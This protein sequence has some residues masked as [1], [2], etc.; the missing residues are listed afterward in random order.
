MANADSGKSPAWKRFAKR[1]TT[2]RMRDAVKKL[3]FQ[4][5]GTLHPRGKR[6]NLSDMEYGINLIGHIRGD[7]GLGESCRLVASALK[8]SEIPFL[9]HNLPLNGPA[10][11][12]DTTWLEA[13]RDELVYGVNLIHLNP[14]EIAN[15]VWRLDRRALHD[16]YNIAYWLWELPEFPPEWGY[17]FSLFDE[18]W[19]P[20]EF[21]SDAIRRRTKKPILTVPYALS[22]PQTEKEYSR[23][24]FGLPEDMFLFML[25][26][27]GNSV[28]ERKN[29]M[30]SVRAYCK[31]F[32][33]DECSV[34]LVIKATH[35]R[36]NDLAEL[37]RMLNG[38]P[39]IFVLTE[40][41]S[42]VEFNS[43][44]QA[45]DVYVSLHRAEGFGLV[46][47]EAMLL[48]TAVVAT[49][50]SANTEFMDASA[51]CMVR[52]DVVA[53]PQD[54]P[55][56]HKGDHWAEPDEAEA[57]VYMRKLYEDSA[58]REALIKNAESRITRLLNAENAAR[59]IRKRA[60]AIFDLRT[61]E[62]RLKR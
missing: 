5:H 35:A 51:A 45:M 38:Y 9:I 32:S 14:N 40:S 16:R 41:Y 2:P 20:S 57:A 53:L 36:E 24:Y 4:M 8:A 1:I 44:I 23:S 55:P 60:D 52:A 19:T 54:H 37:R 56:Y 26:Y 28:S 27:D 29:P 7:F 22:I 3:A 61:A 48:G 13:E 46:M 47:A 12:T 43:L 6:R 33:P 18:I 10:K 21:V 42:K 11:E 17:T 31:A 50:W 25:S 34:G 59:K 30:G 62:R 58:F 39:N 15:A 49:N